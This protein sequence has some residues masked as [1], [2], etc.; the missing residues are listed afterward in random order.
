MSDMSCGHF[1]T[2]H[3]AL[4]KVAWFINSCYWFRG[5]E[6][7]YIISQRIGLRGSES[8]W[9]DNSRKHFWSVGPTQLQYSSPW[10]HFGKH[11][12]GRNALRRFFKKDM[13]QDTPI[14]K[15]GLPPYSWICGGCAYF[16]LIT[17]KHWTKWAEP[18]QNLTPSGF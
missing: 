18:K 16:S 9:I 8:S 15:L 6:R 5:T 2:S 10:P 7:C 14:N 17:L 3:I 12:E 1:I 11:P 4:L 13:K